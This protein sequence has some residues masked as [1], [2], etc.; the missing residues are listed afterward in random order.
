MLLASEIRISH[1]KRFGKETFLLRCNDQPCRDVRRSTSAGRFEVSSRSKA[2][3]LRL[4]TWPSRLGL[5]GLAFKDWASMECC[6]SR[7]R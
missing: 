6:R 4:E 3:A 7:C 2:W 1:G 5:Q